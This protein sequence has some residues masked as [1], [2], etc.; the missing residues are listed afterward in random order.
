M[1]LLACINFM[2]LVVAGF[3]L[4]FGFITTTL[5]YLAMRAAEFVL[6]KHQVLLTYFID[7][8][9]ICVF[10]IGSMGFLLYIYPG[11]N[12]CPYIVN[13]IYVNLWISGM[14]IGKFLMNTDWR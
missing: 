13:F 8:M 3:C 14:S 7:P 2:S 1:R 5:C 4:F 10:F 11:H 6:G 9:L 12:S